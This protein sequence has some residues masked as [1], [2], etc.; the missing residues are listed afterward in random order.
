VSIA[1]ETNQPLAAI[2][3]DAGACLNWLAAPIPASSM[4]NEIW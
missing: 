4:R 3:A 1:H 2:V